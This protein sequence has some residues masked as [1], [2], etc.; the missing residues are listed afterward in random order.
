MFKKILFYSFTF[1]VLGKASAQPSA[2][3]TL[4]QYSMTPFQ[5]TALPFNYLDK[6]D[7]RGGGANTERGRRENSR[8][9]TGWYLNTGMRNEYHPSS[10]L[11]VSGVVA[12]DQIPNPDK[13]PF[14]VGG[15]LMYNDLEAVQI[16]APF[17]HLS[18]GKELQG[19]WRLLGGAG[20]QFAGQRLNPKRLN[21]KDLEDPKVAIASEL[22]NQRL[23]VFAVSAALVH[24]QK[25]Y[26]GV[27][28]N[29]IFEDNVYNSASGGAFT[30]ANLLIEY[31]PYFRLQ[32]N[33]S[34]NWHSRNRHGSTW[35]SNPNR[36][37]FTNVHLSLM[38]R[39]LM[40]ST[41]GYP[42]FAQLN[43]RTT[44]NS[45]LWAGMGINTAGRTQL[46]VGLLKIPVYRMD[47]STLEGHIWLAYDIPTAISPR[48]GVDINLGYFF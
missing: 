17:L 39:Y 18:V 20:Y 21:Y 11:A 25:C 6:F 40:S 13:L 24:V 15:G 1:S 31:V 38:M 26:I 29:R 37:F 34:K 35:S 33:W 28:V 32:D 41:G 9:S 5:P 3:Q 4:F 46:Q 45:M 14:Q 48:H 12:I 10:G 2:T 47:A 22:A 42:L 30:E 16:T 19:E 36:G 44:L 8:L 7:R 43:A 27:G 23:N